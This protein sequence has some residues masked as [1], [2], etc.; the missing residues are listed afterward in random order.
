[1][2]SS[3]LTPFSSSSTAT[4]SVTV[5]LPSSTDSRVPLSP[6]GTI[7]LW[8]IALVSCT[9]PITSPPESLSPALAVGTKSH[10]LLRLS[11]GTSVPRLM[12]APD[13]SRISGRGRWMPS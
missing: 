1:M 6:G 11:A 3:C 12:L 2:L 8:E 9:V 7:I 13:I 10:F 4:V 5:K